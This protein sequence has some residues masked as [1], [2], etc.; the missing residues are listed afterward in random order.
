MSRKTKLFAALAAAFAMQAAWAAEVDF[1]GYLRSGSGSG[2]QSG[3]VACF[4]INAPGFSGD[5]GRAGRL[6]NECDTYGELALGANLGEVE[7][8]TFKLHTLEA[9]GTDQVADYEQSTPAWREAWGEADNIGSGA[10]ANA[11]IWVGKRFYKRHDVHID[12]FFYQAVTGPGAGIE[13]IDAGIGKFSYALMRS[14]D[15]N[16]ASGLS[17]QTGISDGNQLRST[18]P[19]NTGVGF[20]DHDFR[21]EGVGIGFGSLDFTLNLVQNH[22]GSNISSE[23]GWAFT[24]QH[25]LDNPLGLGGFNAFIVQAAHGSAALDGTALTWYWGCTN[26]SLNPNPGCNPTSPTNLG[27]PSSINH[28]GWRVMDHWVFEPKGSNWNGAFFIGHAQEAYRWTNGVYQKTNTATFRPVYHFDDAYSLAFEAGTTRVD[29]GQGGQSYHLNKLTIAPQLS[30]G[31]GFWARPVLRAY[32]TYAQWNSAAGNPA[33]TG[34]D[35]NTPLPQ[36]AGKTSGSSWGVQM[37][38]WW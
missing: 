34:R 27:Q 20:L 11:S 22:V 18:I 33:A 6:G 21:L 16:Y 3:D 29:P 23:N 2:S 4:Q 5:V 17:G 25:N 30:V 36:Y 37:E 35:L 7:G 24:T 32:Y 28:R 26:Q 10:L 19:G 9:F 31:K 13:N 15:A 1:H 12:D 8:I 38:A 14:D